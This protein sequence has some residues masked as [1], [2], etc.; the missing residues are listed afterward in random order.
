WSVVTH[1]SK[2]QRVLEKRMRRYTLAQRMYRRKSQRL[3]WYDWWINHH[4]FPGDSQ[5]AVFQPAEWIAD[6]EFNRSKSVI[7]T[8]KT[9]QTIDSCNSLHRPEQP[10]S[11]KSIFAFNT[12]RCMR[13]QRQWR[14]DF[15]GNLQPG[16][17]QQF[18]I[19]NTDVQFY[20][21]AKE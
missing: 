2:T 3:H 5:F 19:L 12:G 21:C 10:G 9:A 1:S 15:V 14:H 20:F 11:G 8:F 7:T 13:G 6:V 4:R 17:G 18:T 16:Q